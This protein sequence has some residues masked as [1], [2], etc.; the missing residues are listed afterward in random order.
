MSRPIEKPPR[1]G[2]LPA[3]GV[4]MGRVVWREILTGVLI[5]GGLALAS[6]PVTLWQ[7][8]GTDIAVVLS[9]AILAACSTATLVAIALP[10][11]IHRLGWDPAFGSGPLATAIQD[12]LSI[13]VYL[14]IARRVLG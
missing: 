7:C 9:Y 2:P 11:I 1:R 14:E 4:P 12:L 13:L 3:A 10:W 6:I 8:G 5:G